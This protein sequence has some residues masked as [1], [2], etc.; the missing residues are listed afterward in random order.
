MS[1]ALY[2]AYGSNLCARDWGRWCEGKRHDGSGLKVVGIGRLPDHKIHFSHF[3]NAR[4][5]GALNVVPSLGHVAEGVLFRADEKAWRALD[6]KEGVPTSYRRVSMTVLDENGYPVQAFVFVL[7]PEKDLGFVEP[8]EAYL[9]AV[10]NGLRTHRLTDKY[11]FAAASQQTVPYLTDAVFIY[12]TLMDGECRSGVIREMEVLHTAPGKIDGE[13]VNLGS[14]PGLLPG[15]VQGDRQVSGE[16]VRLGQI[17]KCLAVLDEIEGFERDE[18][19][20]LPGETDALG[21]SD[22]SLYVRR[23]AQVK[24]HGDRFWAWTYQYNQEVLPECGVISSGCWRT[25]TR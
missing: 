6:H 8:T 2:F 12:G 19:R 20:I 15:P 11:L 3:S 5:G 4:G 18:T 10:R 1:D 23:L 25:A 7:S 13:I 21:Y 14:Y 9:S 24:V 22:R 17:D 16:F